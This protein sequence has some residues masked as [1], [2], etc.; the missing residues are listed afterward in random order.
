MLK[1]A[2]LHGLNA[3]AGATTIE[4]VKLEKQVRESDRRLRALAAAAW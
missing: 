1:A 3:P 4:D 2:G